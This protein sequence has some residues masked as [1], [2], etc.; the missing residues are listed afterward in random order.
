MKS[1][2]LFI[3]LLA[4][5]VLAACTA[6]NGEEVTQQF[7]PQE[8][9]NA[10]QEWVMQAPTYAYDGIE[11]EQVDYVEQ[12]TTPPTHTVVFN[13]T[14]SSAGY[15]D[16]SDQ[17]TAQVITEH[18]IRVLLVD[19]EVREAIINNEYDELNQQLIAEQ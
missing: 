7:T 4:I 12:S 8:I 5:A 17:M 15:G 13:F 9:T 11:I 3:A 10:A 19:G 2:K 16:R 1:A 6:P 18:Q 14:T